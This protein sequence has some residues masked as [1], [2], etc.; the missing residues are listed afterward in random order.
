M[1]SIDATVTA[2][3]LES[4][5]SKAPGVFIHGY[6]RDLAK[7]PGWKAEELEEVQRRALVEALVRLQLQ[8]KTGRVGP[9]NGK[10]LTIC[11]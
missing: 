4:E 6:C 8:P 5:D 10:S 1:N 3:L 11:T 9:S 2:C 7:Q